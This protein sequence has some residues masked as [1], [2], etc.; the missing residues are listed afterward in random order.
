[1]KT[2]E[3]CLKAG[4]EKFGNTLVIH[5]D[6]EDAVYFAM[7]MYNNQSMELPSDEKIRIEAIKRA[8]TY[9]N[10]TRT[11]AWIDGAKWMRDNYHPKERVADDYRNTFEQNERMMS[12]FKERTGINGMLYEQMK[13]IDSLL[14]DQPKPMVGKELDILEEYFKKTTKSES[15]RRSLD[16]YH[17]ET[18]SETVIDKIAAKIEYIKGGQYNAKYKG[19]MIPV[20]EFNELKEIL[21]NTIE[22]EN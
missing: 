22:P 10:S 5:P 14:N 3:E 15:S 8:E 7:D 21:K 12:W 1:M 17:P 19:K 6:I 16:N 18:I 9:I 13:K 20:I 2:K 11:K 4:Y